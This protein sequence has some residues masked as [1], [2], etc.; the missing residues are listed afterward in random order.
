MPTVPTGGLV[1]YWM[2]VDDRLKIF[3]SAHTL[4]TLNNNQPTHFSLA[5]NTESAIDLSLCSPELGTW[6]RLECRQRRSLQRPLPNL[7]HSNI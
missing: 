3:L 1:S 7:H 5:H 4:V 6:F 2:A